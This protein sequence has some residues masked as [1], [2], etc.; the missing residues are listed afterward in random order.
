MKAPVIYKITNVVN[1]KFYVGSTMDTRERFRTHRNKLRANKHHCHHLQAAW[2][3][4]GEDC[5]KFAVVEEVASMEDLQAAED[6]W[7]IEWVGKPE[8]Y[9]VGMRS[10][11]PMRGMPKELTPNYGKAM[12]EAQ[13]AAIASKL[14]ALYAADPDNHPR[15]GKKHTPEALAKIAANRTPPAGK[16]HYRYGK[17][18]SDEVRAKI[19]AKQ[20]GVPKAA[21]RKVSE[22][23]RAKI[24]ANI[25]AGR[26][27]MHWVGRKH[28]EESKAKMSKAVFV[29]PDGILF[30]S[31]TAVLE[32]YQIKMPTLRRAL[33]SGKP[34]SKGKLAGYSFKYGGAAPIYTLMDKTA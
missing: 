31:L 32:R 34:V 6:V 15:K 21:G 17:T 20:K 28:T 22:E 25:A 19:S 10:G 30:P 2:N 29:M 18:V 14:K 23:G 27:H 3:K 7:L 33:A 16:A 4:Y 8:C 24:Q 5:F 11:A 9:N 13:K 26:S 1:G 12:P